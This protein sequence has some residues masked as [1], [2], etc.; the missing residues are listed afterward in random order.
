M[1]RSDLTYLVDE[2][3]QRQRGLAP[4]YLTLYSLVRGLEARHVLEIGSGMSTRAILDALRETGGALTSISTDDRDGVIHAMRAAPGLVE[5]DE[6]T[7]RWQHCSGLTDEALPDLVTAPQSYD[8]ILH[9]GSH[10]EDV[11]HRD[12]VAAL[13]RLRRFGLLLVHDT[14]H[15]HCGEGMQRALWRALD[16]AARFEALD[17]TVITLPFGFGLTIVRAETDQGQGTIAITRHKVGSH[18]VTELR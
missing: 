9:D 13:P 5:E 18:Y 1:A 6:T 8:L 4:H 17:F 15:S 16:R 3:D 7:A 10:T 11:V 14:L 12:L 2:F